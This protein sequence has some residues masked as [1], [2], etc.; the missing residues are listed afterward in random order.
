[1]AEESKDKSEMPTSDDAGKKEDAKPSVVH[2]QH[3]VTAQSVDALMD[4]I[5]CADEHSDGAG[6]KLYI[7][8]PG[9][10]FG[11]AMHFLRTMRHAVPKLQT[12]ATH[13][14]SSAG[15]MIFLAGRERFA[16]PRVRFL[17]HE[18]TASGKMKGAKESDVRE[19][20]DDLA[21]SQRI[22]AETVAEILGRSPEEIM[23][24]C[25]DGKP[26]GTDKALELGLIKEVLDHS[27][28][29]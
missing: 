27:K 4:E 14:V 17:F 2:W 20:A 3:E 29:P 25:K 15:I 12:V 18:I 1:M 26:I 11:S 24:L 6:V 5:L 21:T 16:F 13:E 28:T 23:A 22:M 7:S 8:S 10:D 19:T 9:G